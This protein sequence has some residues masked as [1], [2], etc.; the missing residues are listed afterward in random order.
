MK[1]KNTTP[2]LWSLRHRLVLAGLGLVAVVLIMMLVLLLL[3]NSRFENIRMVTNQRLEAAISQEAHML[4]RITVYQLS[5]ISGLGVLDRLPGMMKSRGG[6]DK[7]KMLDYCR[8]NAWPPE[9]AKQQSSHLDSPSLHHVLKSLF[10]FM[11]HKVTFNESYCRHRVGKAL[12]PRTGLSAF[13]LSQ[14]LGSRRSGRRLPHY[15]PSGNRRQDGISIRR[16]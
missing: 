10:S 14:A 16:A 6:P 9:Q 7:D 3:A 8:N 13:L 12:G 5:T 15:A 11:W 2:K 1:V 4:A